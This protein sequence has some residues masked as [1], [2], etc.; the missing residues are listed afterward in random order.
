MSTQKVR[1]HIWK[2]KDGWRWHAKRSGKIVAESGEAYKRQSGC[3]RAV[4]A[5]VNAIEAGHCAVE[6]PKG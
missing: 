4:C 5:L 1:F 3:L 2:S 6:N